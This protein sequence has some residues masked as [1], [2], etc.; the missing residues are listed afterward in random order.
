MGSLAGWRIVGGMYRKAQDSIGEIV[1]FRRH[2]PR[3]ETFQC[4]LERCQTRLTSELVN[5]DS[6]FQTPWIWWSADLG[7]S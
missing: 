6:L 2:R 4:R 5:E 1:V 3:A 7:C